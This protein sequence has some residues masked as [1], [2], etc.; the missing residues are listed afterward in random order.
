MCKW[1][2]TLA[3]A[4]ALVGAGAA[5]VLAQS[6]QH[7]AEQPKAADSKA[8]D[9]HAAPGLPGTWPKVVPNPAK[10]P[11]A[12]SEAEIAAGRARC[13][14]MLKGLDVVAMPVDPI[15]EGGCGTAAP[16]QLIAFGK[17]PEVAMS[18][19]ATVTCEMI[20]A[21]HT[22]FKDHVQPAAR[23]LLANPI[24]RINIMSDYS[25][26]NAYGRTRTKL[27]EHGRANAL[28]IKDFVTSSGVAVAVLSDW[29]VTA[30][31]I[32]AAHR[33]NE[34]KKAADAAAAKAAS[35]K[36]QAGSQPQPAP[37]VG[38]AAAGK[39]VPPVGAVASGKAPVGVPGGAPG[40]IVT[41]PSIGGSKQP[42]MGLAPP[43]R[44]GGPKGRGTVM[45]EVIAL[46]RR[47]QFLRRIHAG[48]C[49]VFGTVLGPE[50]NEAHRN[51]FHVDMAER[52]SGSFCE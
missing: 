39:P 20:V 2:L 40:V 41:L 47:T 6:A 14:A 15:K 9:A 26:R 19:P 16:M 44:L 1:I 29:G 4:A 46:E 32:V 38:Q 45:P 22:W 50:A 13:A 30:R 18:P 24:V 43:S 21:M 5:G 3:G 23:D 28:D 31:D 8:G 25:C 35:D 51:H 42:A 7:K 27:S 12:W 33:A 52:R 34:A 17:A 11:P 48:G 36:A 49:R 10:A 37:A